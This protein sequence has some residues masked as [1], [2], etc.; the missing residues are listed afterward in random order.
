MAE[1]ALTQVKELVAELIRDKVGEEKAK[2][3]N[4]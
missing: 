3:I 4:S 2:Q 1:K